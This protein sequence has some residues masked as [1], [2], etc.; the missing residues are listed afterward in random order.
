[1]D[2][3][4]LNE[5]LLE[6]SLLKSDFTFGF[7]LEAIGD[8]NYYGSYEE[9][10]GYEDDD[11]DWVEE[12]N[13]GEYLAEK[14]DDEI[15][16]LFN[17]HS[18]GEWQ[19]GEMQHDGSI[20]PD[21]SYDYPFEWA[22]PVLPVKP[23]N[24]A[25]V[26]RFLDSLKSHGIYVNESCGFHHHL[27]WKGITERDMIWTYTNLAMD[28]EFI[29]RMETLIVPDGSDMPTTIDMA[30]SHW[31]SKKLLSEIRQD[32]KDRNWVN[33]L[34]KYNDSKYRIFRIHPY[35]TIEWRGP[36]NFLNE[37]GIDAIK[38]FYLKFNELL[39]KVIECQNMKT[40]D[41]T[42]IT[43]EQFFNN[44]KEAQ[45]AEG[46]PHPSE[47]M[48]DN[49]EFLYRTGEYRGDRKLR[50]KT[51][52]GVGGLS[53]KYVDAITSKPKLLAGIL[54]KGGEKEISQ[55][56]KLINDKVK[57]TYGGDRI[58][59]SLFD[60]MF[61]EINNSIDDKQGSPFLENIKRIVSTICGAD[62][63]QI[64]RIFGKNIL[65][66]I[67]ADS[68]FDDFIK[69]VKTNINSDNFY[70]FRNIIS[71]DHVYDTRISFNEFYNILLTYAKTK[72]DYIIA[73]NISEFAYFVRRKVRM[74][75]IDKADIKKFMMF[76]VKCIY[77]RGHCYSMPDVMHDL[78]RSAFKSKNEVEYWDNN[79]LGVMF[80]N[81]IAYNNFSRMLLDTNNEDILKGIVAFG[82]LHGDRCTIGFADEGLRLKLDKWL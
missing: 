31:A 29:D 81:P 13:N 42:D 62:I 34:N 49:M 65:Q 11:G 27:S 57:N 70:K 47:S 43:K 28:G 48:R 36:R 56:I 33:L 5:E 24:F 26:I 53:Q 73:D 68:L 50:Y 75:E 20:E 52:K 17:K 78:A 37:G 72:F 51:E 32:I 14:I 8:S 71:D 9:N 3:K 80:E 59:S 76:A 6:E 77:K 23:I 22:S 66:Y 35:G 74:G 55:L 79:I 15:T 60:R 67:D 12:D 39:H 10:G 54:I 61:N 2:K 19:A 41:G 64:S 25:R 46:A 63:S 4:Q 44:L 21:D 45:K 69:N 82:H 30:S 58:I 18:N 38:A 1:M 7:E 16:S 40:I